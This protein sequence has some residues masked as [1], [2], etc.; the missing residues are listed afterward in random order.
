MGII[1]RPNKEGGVSRVQDKIALGFVNDLPSEYDDD[2]D[3]IYAA[4][5][6]GADQV[7]I[8]DNAVATA[9]I[10][11]GAVTLA[12]I[13]VGQT[14]GNRVSA[15]PTANLNITS[16]ETTVVTLPALTTR[17][18]PVLIAGV[19]GWYFD[20]PGSSIDESSLIIKIKRDGGLVF[21]IETCPSGSTSGGARA[22]LPTPWWIDTP[23]AGAYVY[24]ITAIT[25]FSGFHVRTRPANTGLLYAVEFP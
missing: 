18:G 15:A 8:K 9:K 25:T 22:M 24:S 23:G 20:S 7:N 6:G 10:S 13:P 19:M 21:T 11:N 1:A 2:I 17:G 12:K 16:V 5:N 14:L 3:T 4:W